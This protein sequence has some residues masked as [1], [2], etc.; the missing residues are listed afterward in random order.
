MKDIFKKIESFG[1]VFEKKYLN[2]WNKEKILNDWIYS[3]KFFF[4]HSFMRGRRDTLSIKFKDK[5]IEVLELT[6]FKNIK[7]DLE[8][9]S[10]DL[11]QKGVNNKGDRIMVCDTIKFIRELQNPNIASYIIAKLKKDEQEAYKELI[12]NIKY[13]GDKIATLYIRDLCW[14]FDIKL[15]NYK[16]VFPID[17]WVKQIINRLKILDKKILQS[18]ELQKVREEEV[19]E[20]A[21]NVCLEND[22]DPIKF[23]AG[24]WYI[25]THSLEILLNNLDKI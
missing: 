23:N 8:Q 17:T 3:L 13:V 4:E 22:I 16:F 24:I 12:E 20:K 6:F 1:N 14:I 25:G 19:K 7:Y 21:I 9:L 18:K 2:N 15:K 5:A 11:E 10:K